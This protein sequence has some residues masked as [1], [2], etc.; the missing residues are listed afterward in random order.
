MVHG[1]L[2]DQINS[3]S[4]TLDTTLSDLWRACLW[5]ILWEAQLTDRKNDGN[6]HLQD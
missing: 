3:K 5:I 1:I 2:I 6:E 4:L